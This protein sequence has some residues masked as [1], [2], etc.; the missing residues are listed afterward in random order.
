MFPGKYG[1]SVKSS[2]VEDPFHLHSFVPAK[3]QNKVISHG[4]VFNKLPIY[5]SMRH[6]VIPD[7]SS[8]FF[9]VQKLGVSHFPSVD[10]FYDFSLYFWYELEESKCR[11]INVYYLCVKRQ[12]I[13]NYQVEC[14][15]VIFFLPFIRLFFVP[16]FTS[17][18]KR[19]DRYECL[20]PAATSQCIRESFSLFPIE[21]D[22]PVTLDRKFCYRSAPY[23]RLQFTVLTIYFYRSVLGLTLAHMRIVDIFI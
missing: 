9:K 17:G 16:V 10:H 2:V 1:P 6:N 13:T 11:G 14:F 23:L 20:F 19:A 22:L 12:K 18:A 4:C 7:F 8:A 15:S 21:N 3:M 5:F